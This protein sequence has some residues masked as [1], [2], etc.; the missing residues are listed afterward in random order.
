LLEN[1]HINFK[2]RIPEYRLNN[3]IANFIETAYEN[4]NRF[5]IICEFM[6]T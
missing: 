1:P 5:V 6:N 4:T 2:F 3:N